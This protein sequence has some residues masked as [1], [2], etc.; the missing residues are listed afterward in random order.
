VKVPPINRPFDLS[1]PQVWSSGR[2]VTWYFDPHYSD[3]FLHSQGRY[4]HVET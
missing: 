3:P 4:D 1:K 2:L